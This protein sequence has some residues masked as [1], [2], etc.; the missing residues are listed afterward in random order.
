M[1]DWAAYPD[2]A[3]EEFVCQ[4]AC[5]EC[6]GTADKMDPAIL[7][8]LQAIRTRFGG[9]LVVTSG[10][11]CPAHNEKV[12]STGRDGPHVRGVAVDVKVAGKDAWEV[13]ALATR[14]GVPRIGVQQRGAH[15]S[16][17]LHLDVMETPIAPWVWSY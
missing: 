10:Y 5:S 3:P 4:G 16:R 13:L 1:I 9:P 11:R 6:A 14:L 8:K 12:S 17:F 15:E 7:D 2:F